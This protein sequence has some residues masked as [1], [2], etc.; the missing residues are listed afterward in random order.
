MRNVRSS[1]D[2]QSFLED[3][4]S[5][6]LKEIRRKLKEGIDLTD[7]EQLMFKESYDYCLQ[8]IR[9]KEIRN[10]IIR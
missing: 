8:E 5:H 10:I 6:R 3:S 7:G 4:Y 2:A 9:R 1:D